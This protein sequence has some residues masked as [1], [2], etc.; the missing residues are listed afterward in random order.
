MAGEKGEE[1]RL[2]PLVLQA[3][4][5][6]Y[7]DIATSPLYAF[8]TC[9]SEG[10]VEPSA[11]HVLGILSLILWS[12]LLLISVKYAIVVLRADLRGEG[13]ILALMTLVTAGGERRLSTPVLA[14]LGLFGAAL[15]YGDGMI[16]PAM[17]VLSAIEGLRVAAPNLDAAIVPL[18]L[19]ILVSLFLVQRYGSGTVGNYFGPV[20]IAWFACITLLGLRSIVATPAALAAIDPRHGLSFLAESPHSAFLALGSVF[21][22]V[23]GAEA[24]YADLGH[25]GRRPIRVAWFALVLPAL[26]INYIGQGALVLREPAFAKASF[27]HLAPGWALLPLVGLAAAAT[28]VA[29]QAIISG[30]FSLTYQGIHLGLFPRVEVRHYSAEG[31]GKV[32]IPSVN[33]ALLVAA[34]LLVLGFRTADNLAAAYGLAVSGTMAITS[35]LLL[36]CIHHVWGWNWIAS[37]ALVAGFLAIESVFLAANLIKVPSGGW[38]PLLVGAVVFTVMETWKRGRALVDLRLAARRSAVE[39]QVAERIATAPKRVPGTAVYVSR[40][41]TGIPLT[42]LRNLVHNKVMHEQIW[43]LAIDNQAVPRVPA[44]N[45]ITIDPPATGFKRVVAHYGFMQAPSVALL[46]RELEAAGVTWNPQDLTF[47]ASRDRYTFGPGREMS[48]WRKHL[49]ALMAINCPSAVVEYRIPP[50]QLF[51]IGINITL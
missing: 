33:W 48:Q 1:S 13:G 32:Y 31:E 34:V 9:F 24:M 20:M 19:V 12:L 44:V 43:L 46:L 45:R 25:F 42:L 4:G 36:F 49:F 5:V 7:G 22:A 28:V 16:T 41:G 27:F 17:S 21:L 26:V 14:V 35:I 30:A 8:R 23:T 29:S 11:P 18:T 51:E 15:L 10:G 50:E 38:F 6:V 37:V 47:F 40:D 2:G 39:Q 3:L